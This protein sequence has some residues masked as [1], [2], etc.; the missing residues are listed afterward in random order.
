VSSA[1]PGT[2]SFSIPD[3]MLR[4][5]EAFLTVFPLMSEEAAVRVL[6]RIGLREAR[7]YIE[8]Q[9]FLEAGEA[10]SEVSQ[11]GRT[12]PP[13]RTARAGRRLRL[14]RGLLGNAR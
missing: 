4:E 11:I 10:A 8:T 6:V 9:R 12:P 5:V 14:L 2:K 7:R 1:D 3:E 13:K